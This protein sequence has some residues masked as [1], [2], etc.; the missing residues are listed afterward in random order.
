MLSPLRNNAHCTK[1]IL[2]IL[3]KTGPVTVGAD[4]TVFVWNLGTKIRPR[5]QPFMLH[6]LSFYAEIQITFGTVCGRL[7]PSGSIEDFVYIF[8][9]VFPKK[10]F[11]VFRSRDE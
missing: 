11:S 7:N 4:A 2:N 5:K 10:K 1:H 3:I 9:T 8:Y 6:P